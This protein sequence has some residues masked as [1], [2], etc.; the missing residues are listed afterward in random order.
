MVFI[1]TTFTE[2][3]VEPLDALSVG[4]PPTVMLAEP[5]V[6]DPAGTITLTDPAG[7]FV[8]CELADKV[9]EFDMVKEVGVTATM[10]P[11]GSPDTLMVVQGLQL[12][13]E[14]RLRLPRFD[15]KAI[16]GPG[17]FTELSVMFVG[18]LMLPGANTAT[19]LPSVRVPTT[20]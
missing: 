4:S 8:D 18:R 17:A 16:D 5:K 2:P 20:V 19:L 6:T 12:V 1:A 13:G 7:V 11:P 9:E 10:L 3:P 15:P 14:N